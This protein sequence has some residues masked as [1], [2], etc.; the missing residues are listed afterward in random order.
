MKGWDTLIK[1]SHKS[2]VTV[3][4]DCFKEY[5]LHYFYGNTLLRSLST[6]CK[7]FNEVLLKSSDYSGIIL[8]SLSNLEIILAQ[9]IELYLANPTWFFWLSLMNMCRSTSVSFTVELILQQFAKQ[10]MQPAWKVHEFWH[11]TILLQY[12]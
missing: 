10:C 9:C 1:Q 11:I 3:L 5:T 6:V 8:D 12:V 2:W 7:I 4:S